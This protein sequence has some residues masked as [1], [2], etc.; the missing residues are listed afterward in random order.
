MSNVVPMIP[1]DGNGDKPKLRRFLIVFA[2][3]IPGQP[4]QITSAS[5]EAPQP[6]YTDADLQG[7]SRAMASKVQ[8]Q[9]RDQKS[10][11]VLVGAQIPVA[12]TVLS[13]Q[14]LLR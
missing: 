12:V 6:P 10:G 3:Q 7:L 8:V 13:F 1:A 14:E 11:G 4:Q 2:V 5:I 9:A